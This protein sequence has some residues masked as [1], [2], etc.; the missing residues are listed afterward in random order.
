[1]RKLSKSETVEVSVVMVE[2]IDI[3]RKLSHLKSIENVDHTDY[4]PH[5]KIGIE[6]E[7]KRLAK[8]LTAIDK[9]LSQIKGV[10]NRVKPVSGAIKEEQS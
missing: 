9:R 2:A 7:R 3:G 1:M 10:A 5:L 8:E 4:V 6:L